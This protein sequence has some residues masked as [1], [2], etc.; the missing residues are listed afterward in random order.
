[1]PVREPA[2]GSIASPVQRYLESLHERHASDR[3]GEVA[4]Y[5]P[6]LGLADPDWFGICVVTVDGNV[7]E[8]G[9]TH[10]PFSIQ[11]VSKPFTFGLALEELGDD[12]VRSRIGV[13]PTG[14]EF[15]SI[16]LAP[17]TGTPLNP[18]VN[19]GAITAAGLVVERHGTEAVDRLLANLSDYAARELVVDQTVFESEASTGHRNRAIAH[20]LRGSGAVQVDP[21][22]AL[23][24]YF[25]QCS[26]EV[27]AKDLGVMAA[28]LAN[29]GVNALSG[30]RVASPSTVRSMLSV[31]ITCGM[32]DGAGQWLYEVGLPAKSG[33]SG[34][35]LAVQPGQFG[36]AV[37]SPPLDPHGN[38]VRGVKVCKDVSRELALHVIQSGRRPPSPIRT[39]Y[40]LADVG[41]KRVRPESDRVALA[42]EGGVVLVLELQGE[43]TFAAFEI[44]AQRVAAAE[45]RLEVAI[46]D[47]R[48]VR[49]V[50]TPVVGL[51]R[52]LAAQLAA[53]GG[54]LVV[55]CTDTATDTAPSLVA[56]EPASAPV[57]G[58]DDLDL[59]LEWA[60]DVTL[61]RLRPEAEELVVA[62]A[63]HEM[64]AGVEQHELEFLVDLLE[65]RRYEP[66]E[67][68]F[69]QGDEADELLLV[70]RGRASVSVH[71]GE[72]R[73]RRVATLG[74]GALLGEMAMINAEPRGAD[75]Q[76]DTVVEGHVLGV[77]AIEQLLTLR[78]EVRAKLL[79]NVLRIVTRRADRM[80]DELVHLID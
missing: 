78:P 40:T 76:A 49:G 60:E 46:L 14:E 45:P 20:L 16:T 23:A 2:V 75:V 1:M 56:P 3:D 41:S 22:L 11:S 18:M 6:E 79:G 61:R 58:F 66:G 12:L 80:R 67:L 48:R 33:V 68:I 13:E 69:R 43:L 74:A 36:V 25:E 17:G 9:E 4:T 42:Q 26:T 62:M 5:I 10:R 47:L 51:L 73:P 54:E 70:E 15:N 37:Y 44:V 77:G 24:A 39:A 38:S 29:G 30:E 59:A 50:Q 71:D 28:T 65:P 27:D 19:A 35:I 52:D 8:V 55:S 21:D 53:A 64:L 31:M 7:Y 72:G 32:Y 57:R 63:D 34:C